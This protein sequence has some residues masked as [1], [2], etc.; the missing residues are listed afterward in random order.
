MKIIALVFFSN[1]NNGFMYASNFEWRHKKIMNFSYS[2]QLL[3]TKQGG[4]GHWAV[5]ALVPKVL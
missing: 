4:R 2:T 5:N 1:S 3:A